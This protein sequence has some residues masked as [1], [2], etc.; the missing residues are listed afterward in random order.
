MAL[1]FVGST[2][3]GHAW[4]SVGLA[5]SYPNITEAKAV[6]LAE[7]TPC[8][9]DGKSMAG[10]RVFLSPD[11]DGGSREATQLSDDPQAH[12]DASLRKGEQVLVFQYNGKFHAIDNVRSYSQE[13]IGKMQSL[14]IAEMPSL[15]ISALEWH[16]V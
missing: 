7:L 14:I 5:S 6:A 3:R 12:S 13:Y 9:G 11:V 16:P 8:G 1:P 2:L 15:V 10:G 4:F